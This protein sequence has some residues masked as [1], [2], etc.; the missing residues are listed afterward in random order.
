LSTVG[1]RGL[2]A[3]VAIV[4]WVAP[5]AH[6]ESLHGSKAITLVSRQQLDP[7][8]Q[9]LTLQTPALSAPT[10]VRVLLPAG[11]DA[12]PH[13]RYPVLYLLHGA[14]DD[15]R[16]WT[17]KGDAEAITAGSDLIVVMPDSGPTLGYVDWFNGGAFGAPAW[18]TYH[19]DELIP[20]IDRRYRTIPTRDGRAIAGLSMGGGGAMHDA[21]DH[22]DTF[23]YAAG[24]SPAVNL[25]DPALIALNQLGVG[26]DGQPSPA[27]GPYATEEVRWHGENPLDLAANLRG[28]RLALRT[29]N[30]M[31]GGEFGG[32]GDPI[33]E[34]VHRMA[35]AMHAR[36][37]KLGIDHVFEDY[38]NGSHSWPYWQKDL[39][40]ELPL[41][42][43]TF[44]DP[45]PPPARFSYASIDD[46][47]EDYGWRV[48]ID[49]VATEFSRLRVRNP[50]RFALSG[51]GDAV[52][53]TPAGLRPRAAYVVTVRN[54]NDGGAIRLRSDAHG[55]LRIPLALGPPNPVQEYSAAAQATGTQVFTARVRIKRA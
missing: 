28:M 5:V 19:V 3:L 7:R 30:G 43:R 13:R 9:E 12:H 49:R 45:P 21:A 54:A 42:M 47:Y 32:T 27:Y 23:V 26:S 6:A 33:E 35:V 14:V 18:E 22:P 20:W 48:R 31:P 29:G 51:S 1:R 25:R 11:Y 52:V 50:T 38:G 53:R 4:L 8:L 17:D 41:L 36:L 40:T 24:Y 46:R 16:S 44:A 15:Y 37:T 2:W 10:G 34:S 55:S 39:R